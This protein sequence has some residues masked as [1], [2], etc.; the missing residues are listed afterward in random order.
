MPGNHHFTFYILEYTNFQL[1]L[2][3]L[4]KNLVR[5]HHLR[6]KSVLSEKK[7]ECFNC[8]IHSN[9]KSN[10]LALVVSSPDLGISSTKLGQ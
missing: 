7:E 8:P 5:P 3:K 4:P 1:T 9:N 2:I 10:S 6:G